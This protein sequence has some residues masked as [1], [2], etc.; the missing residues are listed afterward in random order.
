[1]IVPKSKGGVRLSVDLTK[2]NKFVRR[3]IH[4][5]KTPKD[6]VSNINHGSKYFSSL[7]AKQGYWQIALSQKCQELNT[8]LTPWG[9]YI[10][11]RSPIGLSSTGDEFCRRGDIAIAGLSN[12]EKVMDDVIL[13]GYDFEQHVDAVR[14]VL[15]RCREYG[16]KL[17]PDKFNFAKDEVKYVGFKINAK[18]VS[19]DPNRLSAIAEFPTPSCV[20]DLRS[21]MGLINQLGDFT[22]EISTAADPLRELLKARNAFRWTETHTIAFQKNK[23]ALESSPTLAHYDPS[24]PTALHTDASRRKGLGYALLQKHS[25]KWRLIQCQSRFI[26]D[27]ESRYAMVELELLAV[28]WVMR[29]CRIQLLGLHHF[30]LVV[31][32]K[33]LVTIL[34]H[35]RLVDIDNTRLQRLKEKTSLFSF[36]TRW[37]KGKDDIPDAL[38]R[39]PMS[40]P[41]PN[42]QEAE[43]EV[44]HHVHAIAINSYRMAM[45]NDQDGNGGGCSIT[46]SGLF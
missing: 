15:L 45:D 46:L 39:A 41:S 34:D 21:S 40:D 14:A 29:K 17:N 23:K 19:A 11:L 3:P 18:G 26:T 12:V 38:S 25:D 35:H 8:F 6:A 1:M 20:T 27:T 7:D 36:T 13:F 9:R 28:A 4:P 2:L 37:T 30:E 32:H 44:E 31:D 22:A 10:F 24:K 42:D 33:P 43:E 5:M 16:I